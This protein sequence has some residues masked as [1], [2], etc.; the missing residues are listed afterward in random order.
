MALEWAGPVCYGCR[1]MGSEELKPTYRADI[2]GL[3]AIAVLSVIAFHYG[4][5]FPA[6]VHL[7]GGFT[8]VD[9]FFVVSGFLITQQ[10]ADDI[11]EG[12]FSILKFYDRRARRILPA[13]LVMLAVTLLAGRWLLLPGDYMNLAM[14]AATA[15]FGA[16]NFYFLLNTGYF[17]QSSELMP[18]LHTWS[19]GVEEQFYFIWPMLLLGLATLGKSRA[20][21]AAIISTIV[22]AG[23]G[24]MLVWAS[25]D[26]KSA[27]Y[28]VAPR[29][30]ELALGALLVFLPPISRLLGAP[31]IAAGLALVVAGFIVADAEHFPG[32]SAVLPCI[33]SALILW[34]RQ[35]E[36]ILAS[37]LGRLSPI[38]L[39]SYS[40]YLWHWPLWVGFRIYLSG[41]TPGSREALTLIAASVLAAWLSYRYIETPFR[42]IRHVP[43]RAIA[44]GLAAAVATLCAC[45][46]VHSASGLP[47]RLPPSARAL[48][49]LETMWTWPCPQP[50]SIDNHP[51]WV[52]CVIGAPW[53]TAS[54]RAM[55]WGDSHAEHL[56]PLL[57]RI[58][59]QQ[60]IAFWVVRG[61]PPIID[62]KH[63]YT[64]AQ[65]PTYAHDCGVAQQAVLRRL[66][67]LKDMQLIV[68]SARWSA[69]GPP[70][71]QPKG[72]AVTSAMNDILLRLNK[73]SVLVVG[74]T[75]YDGSD[76]VGCAQTLALTTFWRRKCSRFDIDAVKARSESD[77]VTLALRTLSEERNF[78]L[79][80]PVKSMCGPL[81]CP[82]YLNDEFIFRDEHHFR[83]NLLP[84]TEDALIKVLDLNGAVLRALNRRTEQTSR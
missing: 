24:M 59:I 42:R 80:D 55:L 58:G 39:I 4:A 5:A 46:F 47:D 82:T 10:L 36:P 73:Y 79:L 71:G 30:W 66:A 49:S 48:S 83:R 20:N 29:A 67:T 54:H 27:F 41:N 64:I 1:A 68:L 19:L 37:W 75:P 74:D 14:S 51:D 43:G 76:Y 56:E 7:G 31:A 28:I 34:P 52:E 25:I 65:R 38:G 57:N 78:V 72:A 45:M 53:K 44:T 16:S 6:W 84:G 11:A 12:R 63:P 50:T 81:T 2:D 13:L 18:L 35:S 23:F 33:G 9:V 22:I 61:C 77:E 26:P 21:I 3:R 32:P 40:L 62:E 60:N 70:P 15:A 17:D 8:G 69:Y